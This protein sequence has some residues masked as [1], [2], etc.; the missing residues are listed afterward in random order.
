MN[1][2]NYWE[3]E[4]C[5]GPKHTFFML[6]G[7]V[8]NERPNGFFNEY[9]NDDFKEYRRVME[10]LG[11]KAFVEDRENQLSGIGVSHTQHNHIFVRTKGKTEQVL[12]VVF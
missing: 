7:C 3:G 10:A 6:N 1:S 12:K 8:N 5:K 9:L 2:P 11:S 4:P